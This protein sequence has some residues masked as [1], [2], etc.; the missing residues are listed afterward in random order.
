MAQ[1]LRKQQSWWRSLLPFPPP[2]RYA[3]L[4][5]PS[6]PTSSSTSL[7]DLLFQTFCFRPMYSI[8]TARAF[9]I[10]QPLLF[11]TTLLYYIIRG[12]DMLYTFLSFLPFSPSHHSISPLLP[13]TTPINVIVTFGRNV[14]E[15]NEPRLWHTYP[16]AFSFPSPPPC[17]SRTEKV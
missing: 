16:I 4:Y 17:D 11:P 13:F 8:G 1:R 9:A 3:T 12:D 6:L 10:H 7:S 15:I 5:T 2:L 14:L